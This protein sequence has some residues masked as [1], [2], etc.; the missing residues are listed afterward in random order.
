MASSSTSASTSPPLPPLAADPNPEDSKTFNRWRK[1]F[2]VITGLG[3][4][5]AERARE[6]ERHQAQTCEDWKKHL[7][8]YSQ[9]H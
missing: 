7:M 5:D 3:M 2:G 1:T 6:M 4:T 9:Y 8:N